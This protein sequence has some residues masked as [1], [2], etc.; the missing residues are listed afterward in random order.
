MRYE[1][2]SVTYNKRFD[3]CFSDSPEETL[4]GY[5]EGVSEACLSLPDSYSEN[6]APVPLVFS[7]HGSG[8]RVCREE[9]VHGGI[10][11]LGDA[12]LEKYAVFDIHGT[13]PDGRSHGNRR[14]VFAV[15][16]AY[17]Y[18]ISHYNVDPRLFVSGG[19]MGGVCAL[20]F[21]N[22]FP[23]AVRAV[24]LFY[25]RTNLHEEFIGGMR[26]HGSFDSQRNP[27]KGFY[28]REVIADQFGF[29]Q[30]LAWEP[31][32]TAGF[33]PFNTRTVTID[34]KRYTFFP[35]PIKVWH[36][37]SDVSVD[38]RTAR[39]YI[40]GIRRAGSMAELRVMRGRGH[41]INPVMQEELGL[42]FDRFI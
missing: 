35:C 12:N 37:D 20:N 14:Y 39:E 24:G 29:S 28:L 31:E 42:W 23:S 41:S 11:Y 2:F 13:R 1:W 25:P 16:R 18:V 9:D 27:K 3:F 4:D 33:D 10:K 8:G 26:E 5:E 15:Y 38:F 7:A 22:T 32:K 34:G 21:V 36:G 30:N 17:N 19:S 6:G 40:A